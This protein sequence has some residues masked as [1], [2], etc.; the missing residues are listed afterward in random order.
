MQ[1]EGK[2]VAKCLEENR[3]SP[4]RSVEGLARGLAGSV[5]L[6]VAKARRRHGGKGRI[7]WL[8]PNHDNTVARVGKDREARPW[9]MLRTPVGMLPQPQVETMVVRRLAKFG[10]IHAQG[11]AMKR[12]RVMFMACAKSLF[13]LRGIG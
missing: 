13:F 9:L 11:R 8:P 2:R 10:T 5:C 3:F 6:V 1:R 7:R 12:P 4:Y